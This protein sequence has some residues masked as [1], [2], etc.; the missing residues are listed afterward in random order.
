[1]KRIKAAF[2]MRAFD[3]KLDQLLPSRTYSATLKTSERYLKMEASVRA[4]GIIDPLIVFPQPGKEGHYVVLDGHVRLEILRAVQCETVT[5]IAALDDENSTYNVHVNR[6]A[7]IQEQRM[8]AKAIKAGVS[9][10]RIATAL[11]V[12]E[13]TILNNR[14]KLDGITEDAIELLKDKPITVYALQLLKRVRPFRQVEMAEL[15]NLSRSYSAP[16]ARALLAT[17]PED[18]RVP[19]TKPST[20]SADLAK[21][22]T[23]MRVIEQEF[24][25]LEETYSTNTLNL[26]LARGYLK[27]L[28]ANARVAKYLTQKHG[29]VLGQI[30]Q[31][32]EATSLEG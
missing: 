6:L 9:A 5:C 8:I 30:R 2:T 12:S 10:E 21:L 15:M 11:R 24:G 19:S 7:A 23:E 22:D 26:Q 20:K 16:Y 18:Q 28:L 4:E 13:K 1:M 3:V 17:T 25:V 31:V 27:L 14:T 32:V 29:D